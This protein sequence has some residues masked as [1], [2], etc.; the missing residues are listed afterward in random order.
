MFGEELNVEHLL[1][2]FSGQN[3]P[4]MFYVAV[5]YNNTF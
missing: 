4:G 1:M 3:E 2:E 5:H